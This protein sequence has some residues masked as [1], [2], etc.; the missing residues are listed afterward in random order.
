MENNNRDLVQEFLLD[1]AKQNSHFFKSIIDVIP[2]GLTLWDSDFN[3]VMCND[4]ATELLGP[5]IRNN[6]LNN[7]GATTSPTYQ[8]NGRLSTELAIEY[9]KEAFEVGNKTFKWLHITPNGEE[10]PAQITLTRIDPKKEDDKPLIAGFTQDLRPFLAGNK[11]LDE[12][13]DYFLNKVSYK[14]LF[15]SIV[16][17]SE[18]LFFMYDIRTSQMQYYGNGAEKLEV[19]DRTQKFPDDLLKKKKIHPDDEEKFIKAVVDAR[20]GIEKNVELRFLTADNTPRYFSFNYKIVKNELKEP[21]YA[22]GRIEDINDQKIIEEKIK[23]DLLTDCYNKIATEKAI[24]DII[25]NN[26]EQDFCFFIVD[27][28]NFKSINDNLGHHFGDIT[29]S[30]VSKN[31]QTCFRTEDIV[32]RIGGDEFVIFAKNLKNKNVIIEKAETI[33]NI[34]RNTYAG[35]NKDYKISASIGIACYPEDGNSFLDLYKAA[36]KALYQSKRKGKDCYTFYTTQMSKG[37]VEQR[38]TLE[39]S[40]QIELGNYDTDLVSSIFTLLFEANDIQSAINASL[41]LIGKKFSADRTY[42][43][44]TFD[45]GETYKNTYEWCSDSITPEID[46]LQNISKEIFD[47]YFKDA[48][49]EDFTYNNV[50]NVEKT[51]VQEM[52]L[53]QNVKSCILSRVKYTKEINIVF[54][55]DDCKIERTWSDLELHTLQYLA[56]FLSTFLKFNNMENK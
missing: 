4:K 29:L 37:V 16:N 31:L 49:I 56:K 44:Q 33:S 8:P 6:D 7:L 50:S 10:F 53:D 32:G 52:M 3:Y 22:I 17:M 5:Q 21:V 25:D 14:T 47:E 36:D 13:G 1:V 40:K 43:F 19:K 48:I 34:C 15:N 11:D 51:V 12:M 35:E 24:K 46:N 39:N 41:S 38:T 20:K 23:K 54:G 26:T 42:I 45:N 2:Y 55:M 9:I 28:D 27:I 30:E 18:K